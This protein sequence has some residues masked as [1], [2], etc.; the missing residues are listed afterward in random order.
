M[1]CSPVV[2]ALF[3]KGSIIDLNQVSW[4]WDETTH[5]CAVEKGEASREKGKEPHPPA[6]AVFLMQIGTSSTIFSEAF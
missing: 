5:Q 1:K 6:A 3:W 2:E 4:L